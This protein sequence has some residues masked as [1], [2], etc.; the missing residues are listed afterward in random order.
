MLY[1]LLVDH[2]YEGQCVYGVTESADLAAKWQM[3]TTY[4]DDYSA[5]EQAEFIRD[6]LPT[7]PLR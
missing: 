2:G 3:K 6:E 5:I 4:Y 1:V 7:E